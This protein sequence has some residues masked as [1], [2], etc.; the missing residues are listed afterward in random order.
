MA[1]IVRGRG[2]NWEIRESERTP[3]GP[4]SRTLATFR[5]LDGET[6]ERARSRAKVPLTAAEL[7]SIARRVGAPV[8]PSAADDAAIQMLRELNSGSRPRPALRRLLVERLDEQRQPSDTISSAAQWIGASPEERGAAL[9]D[10]LLLADALP[11]PHR[12]AGEL[13]FPPLARN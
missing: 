9:R 7:V 1:S 5:R 4:R 12:S 6:I 10:L 13:G 3:R 2:Q 8:A 11:D